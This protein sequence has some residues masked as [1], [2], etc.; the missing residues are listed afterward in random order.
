MDEKVNYIKQ[1]L[2]ALC[3]AFEEFVDQYGCDCGMVGCKDCMNTKTAQSAIN[4]AEQAI[5]GEEG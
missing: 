1:H 5:Q 4:Y 2:S 3:F